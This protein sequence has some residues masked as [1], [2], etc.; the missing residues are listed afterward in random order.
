LLSFW[1]KNYISNHRDLSQIDDFIDVNENF[2]NFRIR[3]ACEGVECPK[4]H[5]SKGKAD[6]D[7]RLFREN[8][9]CTA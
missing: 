3:T 7:L 8:N 6:L 2:E 1:H 5:N 4:Y 9:N